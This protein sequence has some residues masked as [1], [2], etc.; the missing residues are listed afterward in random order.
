M[1]CGSCKYFDRFIREGQTSTVGVCTLV[2]PYTPYLGSLPKATG[3]RQHQNEDCA[4][5]K[6]PPQCAPR[7]PQTSGQQGSLV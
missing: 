7:P 2:E 3:L 1:T 4:W 5:A 6:P